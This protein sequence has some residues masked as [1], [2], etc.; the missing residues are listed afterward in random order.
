[1]HQP[2]QD[3]TVY[4]IYP[5]GHLGAP[6]RND[7]SSEPTPRLEE[8]HDWLPH[9][10]D[11]DA[12][13]LYLGPL[14]ESSAHGYDTADYYHVDRRLGTNETLQNLSKDL[15]EHGIRLVLDAVFNHVGRGFWAFKDV[16]EHGE[17]SQYKD[18]FHLDFSASSPQGDPFGYEGW[19]GNYDL[20][21]LNLQH[22][23]V[24]KHL[25]DAVA[26]W[27][28]DFGISGLRLDAADVMNKGFLRELAQFCKTL[29][30]DFWLMGEVVHGDYAEWVNSDMLDSATNYELYKG[31]WSSHVD[32]NYFELAHS[33]K[34]QFGEGGIYEGLN[35]YTFADNH[36]VNRVASSLT[37]AAHLYPLYMLLFTVPG[38]PSIYA[39]SEWG[40]SGERTDTSD[41]ALRPRLELEKAKANAPHPDLVDLIAQ[42]TR[43]RHTSPALQEGNY[44]ELL[45]D[46]EQLAFLRENAEEKVAVIVNAADEEV[47]LDLNLPA[48]SA[49]DRLNG[50][51]HFEIHEGQISIP[52]SPRWAR[53]LRL[54]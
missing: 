9:L 16:L 2:F 30:P 15:R 40:I 17:N 1:M 47:T 24:R 45:V 42:M 31:L 20:V 48:S 3:A 10:N 28:R 46:H 36:D 19:S 38:V 11:L 43:L 32:K 27:V 6:E 54:S 7:F 21:K 49:H 5:L 12:N 39:G 8:L 33:L 50:D 26:A 29:K 14:F 52:V 41:D 23:D 35:L 25:F 34:R 44:R 22:P 51:E 4:H 13:A 37:E 18:W 53:V